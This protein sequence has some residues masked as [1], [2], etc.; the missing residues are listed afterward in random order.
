[1]SKKQDKFWGKLIIIV[2][3]SGLFWLACWGGHVRAEVPMGK[4]SIVTCIIFTV[5][6]S[7]AIIHEPK[8]RRIVKTYSSDGFSTRQLGGYDYVDDTTWDSDCDCSC[9]CGGDD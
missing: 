7:I 9:D 4:W 2:F 8:K 5:V 3:I 1:M 6:F